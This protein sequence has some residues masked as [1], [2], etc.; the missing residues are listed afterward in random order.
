[1][2]FNSA[3]C[4]YSGQVCYHKIGTTPEDDP[5]VYQD[6]EHPD[7]HYGAEVSD[8]GDYLILTISESCD[9]VNKVYIAKMTSVLS[10]NPEFLKLVEYDF[11]Y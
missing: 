5:V 11:N 8:D 1:M 10:G 6:P 7:Y 2:S 9:P 3:Y 4:S